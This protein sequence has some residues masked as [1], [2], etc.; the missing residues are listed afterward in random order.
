MIIHKPIFS[1]FRPLL[2]NTYIPSIT[3]PSNL[4]HQPIIGALFWV[5]IKLNNFLLLYG[6]GSQPPFENGLHLNI[7]F[8]AKNVPL[9]GPYFSIASNAYCEHVGI[10]LQ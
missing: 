9:K 4:A 7:L 6:T 2:N 10:N 8:K 1:I 5:K 3:L